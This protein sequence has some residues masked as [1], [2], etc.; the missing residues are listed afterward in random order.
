MLS[1]T[2]EVL[3]SLTRRWNQSVYSSIEDQIDQSI[4]NLCVGLCII[5][6][7]PFTVLYD[8]GNCYIPLWEK[9][10]PEELEEELD[11]IVGG[12]KFCNKCSGEKS[13][14]LIRNRPPSSNGRVKTLNTL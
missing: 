9:E 3:H 1:I 7:I 6:V 4:Q 5:S 13:I 12:E 14:F 8:I 11:D 2:F 10:E